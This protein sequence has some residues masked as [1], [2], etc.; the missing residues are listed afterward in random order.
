MNRYPILS[1]DPGDEDDNGKTGD[2]S[3]GDTGDATA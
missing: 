1:V 2:G 3:E